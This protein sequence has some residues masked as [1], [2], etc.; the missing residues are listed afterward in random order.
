VLTHSFGVHRP[1]G[2]SQIHQ[3]VARQDSRDVGCDCID[4][5]EPPLQNVLDHKGIRRSCRSPLDHHPLPPQ[6]TAPSIRAA[7]EK[8]SNADLPTS[9]IAIF[10]CPRCV[11][12][13][14][15]E[16]AH[17][18]V[19]GKHGRHANPP[20]PHAK[21]EPNAEAVLTHQTNNTRSTMRLARPTHIAEVLRCP[22][23]ALPRGERGRDI[24]D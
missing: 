21:A 5:Y 7:S 23:K 2:Y 17:A 14:E 24:T 12:A 18:N 1:Y 13:G 8:Y 15:R 3:G 19:Q 11:G 16:L 22:Q 6:L 20:A 9:D 4:H 10:Q